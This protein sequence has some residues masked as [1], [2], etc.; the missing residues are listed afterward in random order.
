MRFKVYRTNTFEEEFRSL[1][2][3]E[4]G[5]VKN[6]EAKL[7]ENPFVGRPLSYEFFRE[8]RLN[9]KR[10]YYLIYEEFIIVLMTAVS[11]K[12]TQQATIDAIIDKLDEYRNSIK[13][14]LD[15]T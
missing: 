5:R 15:K 6:F 3:S 12:K 7:S 1:S 10:V 4:Q 9:G 14:T 2:K 8:K 11:D 13:E